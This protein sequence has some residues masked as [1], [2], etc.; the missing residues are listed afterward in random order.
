MAT[1][2]G[3]TIVTPP[4]YPPAPKAIEMSDIDVVSAASSAFSQQQQF[5]DWGQARMEWSLEFPLISAARWPQWSAFLA[6]LRGNLSVFQ[7]GDPLHQVIAGAGPGVSSPQVSG[8]NQSG[9]SLL[10]SNWPVNIPNVLLPGDWF[11]VGYRLY[12]VTGPANSNGA[13]VVTIPCWPN[14]RDGGPAGG[15]PLILTATQGLWRLK[16]PARK[17]TVSV[18]NSHYYSLQLDLREAL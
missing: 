13:G 16:S 2:N 14:L 1:F 8:S 7:L 10:T 15:T 17:Y 18:D 11:Q 12:R 6:A 5:Y 3:W 4:A 9:F